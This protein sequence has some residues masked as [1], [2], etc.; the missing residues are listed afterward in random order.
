MD[1]RR[2]R[3]AR[4]TRL[5]RCDG[6]DPVGGREAHGPEQLREAVAGVHA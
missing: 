3:P 4:M 5:R 6:L 2:R 1:Q